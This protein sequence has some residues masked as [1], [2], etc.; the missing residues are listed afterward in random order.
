MD[1]PSFS[2]PSFSAPDMSVKSPF[3]ETQERTMKEEAEKF[4]EQFGKV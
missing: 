4:L 3:T 1:L 2:P